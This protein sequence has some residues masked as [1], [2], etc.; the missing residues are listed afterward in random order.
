V[1]VDVGY[2]ASWRGSRYAPPED[3]AKGADD[4]FVEI[5]VPRADAR[6]WADSGADRNIS[7]SPAAYAQ[8]GTVG[9]EPRRRI[10][11]RGPTM[12][13]QVPDRPVSAIATKI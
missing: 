6:S 12:Q 1:N 4:R 3:T 10:F 13:T 2:R 9:G 5:F 8:D 11:V 7:F